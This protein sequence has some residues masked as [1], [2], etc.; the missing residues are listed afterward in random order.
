M[1]LSLL[2]ILALAQPYHNV[3]YSVTVSV[4]NTVYQFT[5]N[6]TILQENSSYVTFN[7]TV[8]SLGLS[9]T[10]TYV[11]GVNDPY[12]LPENFQA[13]NT[14]NLSFIGDVSLNGIQMQEYK[15]VFNALGKYNIPVVAYFNNGTLYSLNGSYDGVKVEVTQI[16]T[17]STTPATSVASYLP[18]ILF[19]VAIAIAIV[20]L[21]RI[22]KI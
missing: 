6:F 1:L 16:Q 8:A 19:V 14:S 13:F 15:G 21:L 20:V 3:S 17:T 5:Y 12:P 7:M 11:V 9:K 10:T 4:N 18:L 22:G 2:L